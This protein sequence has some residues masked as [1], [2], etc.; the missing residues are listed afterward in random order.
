MSEF[1]ML[2]LF[3]MLAGLGNSVFHPADL[4]DSHTKSNPWTSRQSIWH[5]RFQWKCRPR[6]TV[7]VI[8]VTQLL[9]W[10]Y[11]SILAGLLGLSIV[12]FFII[13]GSDLNDNKRDSIT[14]LDTSTSSEDHFSKL[15]A[16]IFP[17]YSSCFCF[18]ALSRPYRR[19]KFWGQRYRRVIRD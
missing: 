11:A 7:F 6:R 13:F 10:Q 3:A 4:T 17:N 15:I 8:S 16:I 9:N 5:P 1:W 12:L 18:F 14:P 2:L 19:T